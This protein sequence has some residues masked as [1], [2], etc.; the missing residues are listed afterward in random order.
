MWPRL[1]ATYDA[2]VSDAAPTDVRTGRTTTWVTDFLNR[3]AAFDE[4]YLYKPILGACCNVIGRPFK[5]STLH[6]RTLH[7]HVPAQDLHLDFPRGAEDRAVD[8]W[9]MVGFIF[10][11]DAFQDENGATRFAPGSHRW[12]GTPK[13]C[14]VDES[15]LV[16]GCGPASSV[17]VFNGSVWHGH[18]PN[19]TDRPRRSIQGAYLQLGEQSGVDLPAR[20]RPETLGRL[21]PLAK[22]LLAVYVP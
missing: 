19:A 6:A 13:D 9:P 4:L 10:M 15:E 18:G 14:P 22:Y 5:L 7:P 20:M 3:S 11:V 8:K 2:A 1:T 17:I 12:S 16:A 21:S